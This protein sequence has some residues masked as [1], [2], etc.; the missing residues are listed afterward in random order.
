MQQLDRIIDKIDDKSKKFL[1]K[2]LKRKGHIVTQND[3]LQ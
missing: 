1:S 2:L 3:Y